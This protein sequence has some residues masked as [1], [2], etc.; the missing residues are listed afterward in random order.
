[1]RLPRR[2]SSAGAAHVAVHEE[3][4]DVIDT[5]LP[6]GAAFVDVHEEAEDVIM[7]QELEHLIACFDRLQGAQKWWQDAKAI[8]DM[9]PLGSDASEQ[10]T[11]EMLIMMQRAGT[12]ASR[13]DMT[14]KL[15]TEWHELM[16]KSK[17]FCLTHLYL[18]KN[19]TDDRKLAS[20]LSNECPSFLHVFT[21]VVPFRNSHVVPWGALLSKSDVWLD[22]PLCGEMKLHRIFL[23]NLFD[24]KHWTTRF[25]HMYESDVSTGDVCTGDAYDTIK[26]TTTLKAEFQQNVDPL[27][28]LACNM[29]PYLQ[30]HII[31]MNCLS[32]VINRWWHQDVP[33]FDDD[34]FGFS[35]YTGD[36]LSVGDVLVADGVSVVMLDATEGEVPRFDF[37]R[38]QH[39]VP[40]EEFEV[41]HYF[42]AAKM[43]YM[44]YLAV[45]KGVI[46]DILL[47]DGQIRTQEMRDVMVSTRQFLNF[48]DPANDRVYLYLWIEL[49]DHVSARET[50]K[51]SK[52]LMED[53]DEDEDSEDEDED[54]DE[55]E[56]DDEDEM[57][58]ANEDDLAKDQADREQ[59]DQTQCESDDD[60]AQAHRAFGA[61]AP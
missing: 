5:G 26:M 52:L 38:H 55:D 21:S 56:D 10:R 13:Y 45:L 19:D 22:K 60:E 7:L 53:E 24:R 14:L 2:G 36:F 12:T 29:A 17:Q 51:F 18:D 23:L 15:Q 32:D 57:E 35:D 20:M 8:V 49:L 54:K 58:E 50:I 59:R 41:P 25:S 40:T 30:A 46:S 33:I 27:Q 28:L 42:T 4:E 44:F 48:L 16:F 37:V 39:E 1:M 43:N 11:P 3:A 34:V 47:P 9:A 31:E 61:M 6:D